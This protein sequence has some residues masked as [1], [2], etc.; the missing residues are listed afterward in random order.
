M[1]GAFKYLSIRMNRSEMSLQS[2]VEE[3]CVWSGSAKSNKAEMCS[4]KM[5]DA[6]DALQK[7]NSISF[8]PGIL[9]LRRGGGTVSIKVVCHDL[10]FLTQTE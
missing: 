6:N 1:P 5:T 10:I 2:A 7:A 4:T 9:R 8:K 3:T